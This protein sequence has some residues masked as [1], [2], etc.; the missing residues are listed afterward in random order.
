MHLGWLG[1]LVLAGLC[2]M[3]GAAVVL[4]MPIPE[5]PKNVVI[6][7]IRV[8]YNRDS[9]VNFRVLNAR[10]QLGGQYRSRNFDTESLSPYR[11]VG[12]DMLIFYRGHH[13]TLDRY[14]A[15]H[16]GPP[17]QCAELSFRL[18]GQFQRRL[19][20][21]WLYRADDYD[22]IYFEANRAIALGDPTPGC[23]QDLETPF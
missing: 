17:S 2:V 3:A 12:W 10:S 16:A 7:V 13:D 5:S 20:N 6:E 8:R 14:L 15:T 4:A 21:R 23:G 11:Y 22:G 19:I 9:E 18:V 1:P